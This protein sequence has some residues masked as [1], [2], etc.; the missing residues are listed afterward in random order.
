MT[1]TPNPDQNN[2]HPTTPNPTTPNPTTPRPTPSSPEDIAQAESLLRQANLA[3]VRG[4]NVV[5]DRLLAEAATKAPDSPAVLEAV[6]DDLAQN[7]NYRK[8]KETYDKARKLDPQN[9]SLENKYGEMVLRVDLK[10]DPAT[11]AEA[12]VGTM[13]N[14]KAAVLL[15][16]LLP[17]SGYFTLGKTTKALT[18]LALY[19]ACAAFVVLMPGGVPGVFAFLF[20]GA[21]V[22]GFQPIVFAAVALAALL[23]LYSIFDAAATA[24]RLTPTNLNRPA[25]PSEGGGYNY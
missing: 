25:P 9:K 17:G 3:R 19:L 4:Q 22:P 5:A 23:W 14:A 8:A 12:D 16:T 11:L 18:V 13:A 20:Q 15:N 6:A 24:R 7:G 21:T 2:P 10:I 1:T